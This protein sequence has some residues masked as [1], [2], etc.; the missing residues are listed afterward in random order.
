MDDTNSDASVIRHEWDES[1]FPSTAVVEAVAAATDREPTSLDALQRTVDVDAV[2]ALLASASAPIRVSFSYEA[3][4]V[5]LRGDGHV[6][7]RTGASRQE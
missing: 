1:V 4:R 2:D 6:E 7:V 3:T 5:V